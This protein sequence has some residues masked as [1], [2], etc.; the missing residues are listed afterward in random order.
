MT[1]EVVD[2]SRETTSGVFDRWAVRDP[3]MAQLTL[4]INRILRSGQAN[5]GIS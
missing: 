4:I 2:G 1:I 3:L 5:E